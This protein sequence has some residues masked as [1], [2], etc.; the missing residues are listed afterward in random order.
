MVF[1]IL[2]WSWESSSEN[3]KILHG[4]R[5]PS[6]S[7]KARIFVPQRARW[8]P[9][10]KTNK[11]MVHHLK[12]RRRNTCTCRTLWMWGGQAARNYR[13]AEAALN[14][15]RRRLLGS[16]QK[17]WDAASIPGSAEDAEQVQ[18]KSVIDYRVLA[19]H[20]PSATLEARSGTV[21]RRKKSNAPKGSKKQKIVIATGRDEF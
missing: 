3:F 21:L 19:T 7:K 5:P 20:W 11:L 13:V 6:S 16:R 2:F 18:A 4:I 14:D 1:I 10:S 17:S 9:T 12:K 15:L 8:G